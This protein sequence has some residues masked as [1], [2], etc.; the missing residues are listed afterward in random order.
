MEYLLSPRHRTSTSVLFFIYIGVATLIL[1]VF[2][3][4]SW[5]KFS[6][7]ILFSVVHS[8]IHYDFI[9]IPIFLLRVSWKL[10]LFHW[11]CLLKILFSVFLCL[12]RCARRWSMLPLVRVSRVMLSLLG[13]TWNLLAGW[14][15]VF[16][17]YVS[18][19]YLE[20]WDDDRFVGWVRLFVDA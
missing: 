1:Q 3:L 15:F 11:W 5:W 6:F 19:V 7:K 18:V 9:F 20:L 12:K 17:C 2:I 10:H 8:R 14:S 4:S 16:T 13:D